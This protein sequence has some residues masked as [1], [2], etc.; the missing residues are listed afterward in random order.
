[1]LQFADI[2]AAQTAAPPTYGQQGQV[3]N[4]DTA[5]TVPISTPSM[6]TSNVI[7][8]ESL[9]PATV[10][11]YTQPTIPPPPSVENL[12]TTPPLTT[13]PTENK[14]QSYTDTLQSLNDQLVGKSADQTAANNQFGVD[15]AQKTV[16]DLNAQLTNLKNEAI[17]IPSLLEKSASSQGVSS[18]IIDR[19]RSQLIR[20]NS[21]QALTVSSLMAAAQGQ[22]AN[23]QS[24]ADKAVAAKYG[25]IEAQIEATKQNLSIILNSP[26]YSVEEKNRAQAQL[27]VQNQNKAALDTAKQ[28]TTDINKIALDA[29]GKGADA[30]TLQNIS[31]ATDANQALQIASAAGFA[32][33]GKTQGTL[34]AV[35]T[36]KELGGAQFYKY[37][38]SSQVYTSKGTAV[39]LKTYKQLT[40][41]SAVPDAN[42]NFSGIKTINQTSPT[43]T[44]ST[45]KAGQPGYDANGKKYTVSSASQEIKNIWKGGYIQGNGKISSSDYKNG[46]AWWISQG[47]SA[48]TFDTTFVNLIDQSSKSWKS[49]YAYKGN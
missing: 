14:A 3:T 23:A 6:P 48:A 34:F 39:D 25:P 26:Q 5:N 22:L 18:P 47:L 20:D 13:T 2:Q 44:G 9:T 16:T 11:G 17:A 1:M 49:D 40:G 29:A 42:V 41:Q 19:Q 15:A 30:V 32:S 4:P 37:P 45:G 33:D 8:P 38:T 24:L 27:D 46:K 7:T 28:T 12:Y 10:A 36:A 21:I 43:S 31:K 35:P